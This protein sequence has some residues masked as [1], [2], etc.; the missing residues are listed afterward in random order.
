MS[1][2]QRLWLIA[3]IGPGLILLVLLS[4]YPLV[5][6]LINSLQDITLQG[7]VK[8]AGTFVGIKNYISA[9]TSDERFINSL[10]VTFI[11]T[12]F[13]V[14]LSMSIGIL[15]ALLI[16][17]PFKA[18]NLVRALLLIPMVMAPVVSGLI[19]RHIFFS[20]KRGIINVFLE[21]FGIQGPGWVVSSPW[22][23]I[24]VIFVEIWITVPLVMIIIDAAL[25]S[26]PNSIVEAAK[27]DGASYWR[28]VFFIKIPLIRS[29]ILMA[30]VFR[31]S[32]AFRSFEVVFSTTEGGPGI[33]TEVLGI[34][35][36]RSALSFFDLGYAS[37]VAIIM[38]LI[39]GS[40]TYLLLIYI[41]KPG[42]ERLGTK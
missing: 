37:A 2:K 6:A 3:Y 9:F 18:K 13:S 12:V 40:I 27:I 21:Y 23:L 8:G 14:P 35:V 24:S 33:S 34:Y 41:M 29:S 42:G 1:K 5:L 30:L 15:M 26:V 39:V 32:T 17:R 22:A 36:Y 38:A 28:Q 7:L 20:P 25:M 11:Y 31:I 16:E 10:R 19:W 4:G